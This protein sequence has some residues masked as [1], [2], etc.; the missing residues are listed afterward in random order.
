MFILSCLY[1]LTFSKI[2]LSVDCG[3]FQ[4]FIFFSINVFT[5][6]LVWSK[7]LTIVYKASQ[8]LLQY[9]FKNI[10]NKLSKFIYKH[11]KF[12]CWQC[13]WKHECGVSNLAIKFVVVKII[14]L[15]TKF[16]RNT[17]HLWLPITMIYVYLSYFFCKIQLWKISEWPTKTERDGKVSE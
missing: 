5:I 4:F 10:K 15:I 7:T 9:K 6:L 2:F 13:L 1:L 3:N 16:I 11:S 12:K 8:T 14:V 17:L